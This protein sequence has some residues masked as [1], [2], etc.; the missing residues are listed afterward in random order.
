MTHHRPK[1]AGSP[2]FAMIDA[3]RCHPERT[4]A[5]VRGN[6]KWLAEATVE[7]GRGRVRI[8]ASMDAAPKGSTSRTMWAVTTK[9]ADD[10][11][12]E[13]GIAHDLR[14]AEAQALKRLGA[15]IKAPE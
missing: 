7:T 8:L 12:G 1:L 5:A 14:D 15:T 9:L 2:E 13:V 4:W 3:Q 11:G 10:T 6:T